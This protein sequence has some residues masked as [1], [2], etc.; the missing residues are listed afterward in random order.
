MLSPLLSCSTAWSL[1]NSFCFQAVEILKT[2]REI[3]MRVRYFPY[4]KCPLAPRPRTE[5]RFSSESRRHPCN[6]T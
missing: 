3:T 1:S 2:A 5:R 4:S 6:S